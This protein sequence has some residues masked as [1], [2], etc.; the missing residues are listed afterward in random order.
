MTE[1]GSPYDSIRC[2]GAAL[3]GLFILVA[4]ITVFAPGYAAEPSPL[5]VES[6]P[7]PAGPS[8]FRIIAVSRGAHG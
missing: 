7:W 1:S 8:P 6:D 5:K 3:A 4:T 2:G